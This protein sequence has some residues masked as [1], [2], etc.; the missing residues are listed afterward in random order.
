MVWLSN[1]YSSF[2]LFENQTVRLSR[3]HCIYI[4]KKRTVSNLVNLLPI[5]TGIFLN[6]SHIHKC[7]LLYITINH[8]RQATCKRFPGSSGHYR[9]MFRSSLLCVTDSWIKTHICD[10]IH[11]Q[12]CFTSTLPTFISQYKTCRFYTYCHL[13]QA[14]GISHCNSAQ[15]EPS[16]TNTEMSTEQKTTGKLL[17]QQQHNNG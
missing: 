12:G 7:M 4:Y 9:K 8:T 6:S 17:Q 13:K 11:Q 10:L 5:Y 16:S 14:V 15:F 2:K 1:L 3:V